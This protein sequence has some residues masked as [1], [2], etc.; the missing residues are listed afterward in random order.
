MD[1]LG[2]EGCVLGGKGLVLWSPPHPAPK[3]RA[4]MKR[5]LQTHPIPQPWPQRHGSGD[6][7]PH[8]VSGSRE[9]PQAWMESLQLQVS[10]PLRS[11][12]RDPQTGA[13][14]SKGILFPGSRPLP[15]RD[16]ALSSAHPVNIRCSLVSCC[17]YARLSTPM[18]PCGATAPLHAWCGACVLE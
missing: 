16:L 12:K 3:H 4:A 11:P 6:C 14:T 13:V 1:W 9:C 15:V 17:Q 18:K 8:P 10:I 2:G 7:R 5:S